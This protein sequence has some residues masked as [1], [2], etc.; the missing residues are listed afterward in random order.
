MLN[1]KQIQAIV[2]LTCE[3]KTQAQAAQMLQIHRNTITN[4]KKNE[5]FVT[6][7]ENAIRQSIK[8]ASVT[9]LR[10][11]AGLLCS[12]NERL[13]FQVAKDILDRAG[14]KSIGSLVTQEKLKLED[15]LIE[16]RFLDE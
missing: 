10:I 3:H 9:A 12:P 16:E 4:W 2:L 5:E 6:E 11:M 13:R 14:Y 8:F 7:L 15:L 1:S